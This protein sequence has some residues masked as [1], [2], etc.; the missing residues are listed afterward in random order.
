MLNCQYEMGSVVK[1]LNQADT[2]GNFMNVWDVAGTEFD[3][4]SPPP[5]LFVAPP[6]DLNW[7][8]GMIAALVILVGAGTSVG[9]VYH[10][11]FKKSK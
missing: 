5:L 2:F 3:F 8:A 7:V 6:Q 11:W 10:R 9:I 4:V 1:R